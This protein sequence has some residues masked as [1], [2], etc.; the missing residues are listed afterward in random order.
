[1]T[2]TIASTRIQ[3]RTPR[4]HVG[5][6]ASLLGVDTSEV[7][8]FRNDVEGTMKAQFSG[9]DTIRKMIAIVWSY[10]SECTQ[11]HYSPVIITPA[12]EQHA[13]ET[14]RCFR[15]RCGRGVVDQV[16]H[17]PGTIDSRGPR[18][19]KDGLGMLVERIDTTLKQVTSIEIVVMCG[20]E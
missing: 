2:E 1:M 16:R 12:V 11:A 15:K 13:L 18:V 17:H 6:P 19:G 7:E 20:L 9:E 5:V 3:D 14:L 10:R 4:P 8:A